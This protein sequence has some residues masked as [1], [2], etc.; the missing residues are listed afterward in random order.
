MSIQNIG[1]IREDSF[2]EKISDE[3]KDDTSKILL[4]ESTFLRER[5]KKEVSTLPTGAGRQ[6]KTEFADL[7]DFDPISFSI[8]FLA[9]S[10]SNA[11]SLS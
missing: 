6:F 3:Y 4:Q 8:M 5:T 11:G 1:N 7:K 2:E 10:V 9:F